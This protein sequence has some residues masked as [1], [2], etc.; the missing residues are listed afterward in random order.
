M[1]T[2]NSN[3]IVEMIVKAFFTSLNDYKD[4]SNADYQPCIEEIFL[5]ITFCKNLT[6]L[7]ETGREILK[8]ISYNPD[9]PDINRLK[10]FEKALKSL[11]REEFMIEEEDRLSPNWAKITSYI[12]N[13]EQNEERLY[14]VWKFYDIVRINIESNP[15]II[16]RIKKG[17]KSYFIK[18]FDTLFEEISFKDDISKFKNLVLSGKISKEDEE[19]IMQFLI[20]M[21]EDISE[22]KKQVTELKEL[23]KSS[24]FNQK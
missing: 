15:D 24:K 5:S 22:H 23:R 9:F 3:P 8:K 21:I 1:E 4:Y 13:S 11:Y 10:L 7:C 12:K 16:N 20:Y 2:N 14:N 19:N 17:D 6:D 18:N